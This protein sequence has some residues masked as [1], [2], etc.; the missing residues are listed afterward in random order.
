MKTF[1]ILLVT[2]TALLTANFAFAQTWTQTTAP[3]NSWT[4]IAASSDGLKLF[5]VAS[6]KNPTPMWVSTN[7]GVSWTT[8]SAPNEVWGYIASSADGN[9][10]LASVASYLNTNVIFISTNAG[11]TWMA[12][13]NVPVLGSHACSAD[14][15]KWIATAR[16]G[17][18]YTSTN[19]GT[20]WT[21]NNMT[22]GA[23][24]IVASSADGTGLAA[25]AIVSV[26]SSQIYVST[27]SG[28]GWTPTSAPV[29]DWSSL[30][31]SADGTK[32][33]AAAPRTAYTPSAI[34]TSTNS[35]TSW[36]LTSAPGCQWSAIASSADGN[37]LIAAAPF[38]SSGQVQTPLYVS[39]N[40]GNTWVATSSP[41]TAWQGVASSA[42]GNKL[43]AI[44]MAGGGIWTSQTTPAPQLNLA[45][46]GGN[47]T[48]SWIVPS[49]NFV[50]QQSL[51]LSSWTDMTNPPVL[52]LTNLQNE[53][54]L[55]PTNSSGFYRLKTP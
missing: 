11:A 21:S 19:S 33:A 10:L 29:L 25:A 26:Y 18:I 34:Y 28:A 5:A 31:V 44:D 3:N 13:T 20:T 4:S 16:G 51:D 35:G 40:A 52:N 7:S 22:G 14:G 42:D 27:N 1:R 47:L 8:N 36:K 48:L 39:T 2:S 55:S 45:S 12:N 6:G 30:A 23:W 41:R 38:D 37:K 43:V 9:I 50:M 49:T 15:R 46:S 54:I 53:V 32:L 24:V 17:G